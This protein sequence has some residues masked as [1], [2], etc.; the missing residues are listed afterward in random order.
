VTWVAGSHHV[1]GIE[2][3]LG[4]LWY[5][6]GTVLLASTGGEGSETWHEE[7]KTW[8]GYH[9]DSQ[10]TEISIQLTRESEAGGDSRHGGRD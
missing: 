8:E 5:G 1:L 2:H 4:E 3:L 10:F 9:V 6:Q 7:V